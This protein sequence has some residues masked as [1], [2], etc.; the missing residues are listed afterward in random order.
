MDMPY[1]PPLGTPERFLLALGRSSFRD[2][3]DS[4]SPPTPM[5]K[6]DKKKLKLQKVC[7]EQK[8]NEEREKKQF[9]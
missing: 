2:F 8:V 9:G 4:P 5:P 3:E 7:M 1:P 6:S